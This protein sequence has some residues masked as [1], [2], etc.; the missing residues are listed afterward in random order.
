M[1]H[2][3]VILLVGWYSVHFVTCRPIS[4]L[5][6]SQDKICSMNYDE[7]EGVYETFFQQVSD[8]AGKKKTMAQSVNALYNGIDPG[9]NSNYFTGFKFQ[10]IYNLEV[11]ELSLQNVFRITYCYNGKV[12]FSKDEPLSVD[13]DWGKP[14]CFHIKPKEN[15][16][17]SQ[18]SL[19]SSMMSSYNSKLKQLVFPTVDS[20]NSSTPLE[21]EQ[22]E[23]LNNYHCF[24]LARRKKYSIR[25][26]SLFMPGNWI[27]GLYYCDLSSYEKWKVYSAKNGTYLNHIDSLCS[28]N[29]TV[30][31]LP[32]FADDFSKSWYEV[33]PRLVS[34][35][36]KSSMQITK[37]VP[38][39]NTPNFPYPL[40]DIF[41]STDQQNKLFRDD[42]LRLQNNVMQPKDDNVYLRLMG[43][44]DK[45]SEILNR[46]KNGTVNNAKL[47]PNIDKSR[48][49][50]EIEVQEK[51]VN[52]TVVEVSK[53]DSFVDLTFWLLNSTKRTTEKQFNNFLNKKLSKVSDTTVND[54]APFMLSF[55]DSLLK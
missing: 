32:L 29:N 41:Q 30:P 11:K 13:M 23:F 19:I 7:R 9:F 53:I 20:K 45:T 4:N 52:S 34:K 31:L 39:I 50:N 25:K 14:Y 54:K 55:N 1:M 35:K 36:R 27:G 28:M 40:V 5:F 44:L 42:S 2:V 51:Y 18:K 10:R 3:L 46:Q 8:M 47:K 38:Y 15:K 37:F 21:N 43:Y 12:Q 17:S 26:Y 22:A 48:W 6:E 49:Y 33:Q 24:K 16:Q